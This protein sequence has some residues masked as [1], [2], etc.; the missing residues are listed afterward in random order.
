MHK[1]PAGAKTSYISLRIQP[2]SKM[3]NTQSEQQGTSVELAE[4]TLHILFHSFCLKS[5]GKNE[6][7]KE[8]ERG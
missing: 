6:R 2:S 3:P 1:I 5:K 4:R 7:E 8:K